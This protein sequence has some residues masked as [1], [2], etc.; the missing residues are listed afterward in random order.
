MI[1]KIILLLLFVSPVFSQQIIG[2]KPLL[3]EMLNQSHPLSADLTGWLFN[4]SGG[5]LIYGFGEDT[6]TDLTLIVD[7]T[8]LWAVRGDG[9]G[10]LFEDPNTDVGG[11]LVPASFI[12]Q[13]FWNRDI[14][15]MTI[16]IVATFDDDT[17][18]PKILFETG[19]T[20]EGIGAGYR[21][22]PDKYSFQVETSTTTTEIQSTNTFL[23]AT[24]PEVIFCGRFDNGAMELWI[25]GV[26]EGTATAPA[27]IIQIILNGGGGIG[28]RGGPGNNSVYGIGTDAGSRGK[29]WGGVISLVY[30]WRRALS[31][32]QIAALSGGDFYPMFEQPLYGRIFKA[33]AAATRRRIPSRV[34]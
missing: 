9:E 10:L 13:G 22:G 5:S 24:D 23:P 31:D 21:N 19:N 25:N 34:F 20:V 8:L 32:E 26:S 7:P 30:V 18:G 1:K 17:N 11:K 6:E 12:E 4:E 27:N 2:R 29:E 14:T 16:F 15:E 33:A 3:G 28:T